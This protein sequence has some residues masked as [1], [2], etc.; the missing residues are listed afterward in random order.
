[1]NSCYAVSPK[2]RNTDVRTLLQVETVWGYTIQQC[3]SPR[4]QACSPRQDGVL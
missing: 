1:M 2:V 3:S 4:S